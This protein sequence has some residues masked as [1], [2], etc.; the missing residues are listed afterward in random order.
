[1]AGVAA[2]AFFIFV[3]PF[4]SSPHAIILFA[5]GSRDPLWRA[6]LEA[7]A[8]TIAAKQPHIPVRCAYLELCEPNLATVT[9]EIIAAC[10]IPKGS[11][12]QNSALH[13]RIVPMFLGMGVH[14]R[15]DLPELVAALRVAHPEVHFEVVPPIGEDA[16][17]TALLADLA[18]G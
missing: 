5:H 9:T 8:S 15:K 4:M 11:D 10:A 2:L 7:V 17:V 3:C 12:G 14:A 6:P 1:L 13:V 16:R 18:V